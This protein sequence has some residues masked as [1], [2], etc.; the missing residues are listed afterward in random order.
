MRTNLTK[1]EFINKCNIR[2]A[3][4]NKLSDFRR[5]TFVDVLN[6]FDGKVY[7]KR[8]RDALCAAFGDSLFSVTDNGASFYFSLRND[9]Y[10][11]NDYES[12][13]VQLVLDG[14]RI[15][16]N[17]TLENEYT[18]VLADNFEK[19]TAEIEKGIEYYDAYLNMAEQLERMIES[20]SKIPYSVRQ[21]FSDFKTWY[22]K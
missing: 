4:R 19:E 3:N 14:G 17:K 9:K 20:Y 5:T 12:I 18:K 16:A 10:N 15:S 1:Q 2:I 22:L 13:Y 21:N 7:N 11:Y 6:K 8:F